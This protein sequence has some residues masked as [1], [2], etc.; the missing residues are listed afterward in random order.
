MR[1]RKPNKEKSIRVQAI[2]LPESIYNLIQ[3]ESE[4]HPASFIAKKLTK[5]YSKKLLTK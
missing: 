3:I 2:Y 1:G 4:G 5:M